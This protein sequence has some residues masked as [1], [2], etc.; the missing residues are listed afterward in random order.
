MRGAFFRW[1]LAG[2]LA[3]QASS[4]CEAG[5]RGVPATHGIA[6]FG[7]V[8][9]HL[10]RGAQPDAAGMANLKELGIKTVIC[11]RM[12]NDLWGPEKAEATNNGMAF[13]NIPLRG[14]ARPKDADVARAL[15]MIEN[16]P[17]PAFVHCVF[18][19]DRTGTI[20][21]CYR[22]EHD[23]W[24]GAEAQKEAD[25]YGMSSLEFGMKRFIA[26][27]AAKAARE[28]GGGPRL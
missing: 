17:G 1:V 21:A 7:Q 18:G 12:T 28:R 24:T 14:N 25:H 9:D 16:S 11:L 6:N 10:F 5:D 20:I 13:I 15:S 26:N 19:C 3:V 8:N 22:I 23:H 4:C 2:I 27:F